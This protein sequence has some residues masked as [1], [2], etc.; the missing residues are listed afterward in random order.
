MS[1]GKVSFPARTAIEALRRVTAV[2]QI[3]IQ[4]PKPKPPPPADL[5]LRTPAGR[6]L[7]Y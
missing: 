6:I 5:D 2:R 7:P 1:Y 3:K 4:K